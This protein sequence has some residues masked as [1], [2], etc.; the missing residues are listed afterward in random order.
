[1]EDYPDNWDEIRRRVYRRDNYTCKNCGVRGVELHTHHV[2]PLKS[3][4]SNNPGNLITLCRRCH[5]KIHPH[6]KDKGDYIKPEEYYS[7]FKKSYVDKEYYEPGGYYTPPKKSFR[8]PTPNLDLSENSAKAFVGVVAIIG[9]T[10]GI[11]VGTII[12]FLSDGIGGAIGGFVGGLL[13]GFFVGYFVGLIL[14]LIIWIILIIILIIIEIINLILGIIDW[15]R[16][17]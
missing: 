8:I 15:I 14:G 16:K 10:I 2:V 12:G 13:V 5:R 11:I 4:G 9:A 17:R 7:D 3:G 1:M 6:M